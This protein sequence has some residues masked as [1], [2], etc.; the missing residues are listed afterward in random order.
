MTLIAFDIHN[1]NWMLSK[2]MVLSG[3]GLWMDWCTLSCNM[4]GEYIW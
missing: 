3:W 2:C 1:C 4:C